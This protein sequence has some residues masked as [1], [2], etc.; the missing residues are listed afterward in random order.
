MSEITCDMRKDCQEP[1]THIGEKGYVY[2]AKH[3]VDRR[4]VER[5]RKMRVWELQ[6][7]AKGKALPSYRRLPEPKE[8][9]L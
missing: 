6:W 4:Y 2:C 5:T 3:A 7:L 1:V 8:V 9:A